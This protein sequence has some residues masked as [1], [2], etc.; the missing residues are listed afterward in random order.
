M[1]KEAGDN[2]YKFFVNNQNLATIRCP[3]CGVTKTV[4]ATKLKVASTRLKIT[5]K[6]GET[7]RSEIEF[8]KYYRKPV[9]LPGKYIHLTSPKRGEMIVVDL[10]MTGL[11]FKCS[12]P[13]GLKPGDRLDVFFKL[14]N[15]LRSEIRLKVIVRSVKNLFVGAERTDTALIQDLGFYLM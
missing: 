3:K 8:R 7:F 4:D 9:K 5:C 13:H 6:C 1:P 14:D 15:N 11:G 12:S 2:I 10:S